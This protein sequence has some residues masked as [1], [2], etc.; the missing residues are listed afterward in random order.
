M[1]KKFV[2]R[3]TNKYSGE[4]GF[5]KNVSKTK[6]CFIN[7]FD[8]AEA[9][10]YGTKNGKFKESAYNKDL[11]TLDYIGETQNNIFDVIDI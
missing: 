10:N 2:V 1:A 11:E 6:G 3:W 5:V 7:T 4:Q 9:K 8:I